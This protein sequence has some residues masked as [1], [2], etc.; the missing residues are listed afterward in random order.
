M[1][2]FIQD[3]LHNDL[4]QFLSSLAKKTPSHQKEISY[5]LME[6]QLN[7]SFR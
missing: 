1:Q 5:N 4:F 2:L 6:S 7:Q 3:V